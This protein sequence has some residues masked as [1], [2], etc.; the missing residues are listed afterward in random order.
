[1]FEIGKYPPPSGSHAISTAGVSESA[2]RIKSGREPQAASRDAGNGMSFVMDALRRWWK[3]MIPLGLLFAIVS[4]T[5]VFC[6]F[7]PYYEAVYWLRIDSR[8]QHIAFEFKLEDRESNRVYVQ[9][10]IE[11]LRSP[12]ILGP[13]IAKPEI[14]RLPEFAQRTDPLQWL[15]K[16]VAVKQVG[17]SELYRVTY[18]SD[19]PS[20]A[21]AVVNAIVNEYFA[22]YKRQ[23]DTQND[24]VVGKLV[25]EQGRRTQ[26]LRLL[27]E[28]VREL[29]I[30]STGKDPFAGSVEPVAVSNHPLAEIQ[31]HLVTAEV[32]Q[33]VLKARLKALKESRSQSIKVSDSLIDSRLETHPE[34]VRLKHD[35]MTMRADLRGLETISVRKEKDPMRMQLASQIAN[36]EAALARSRK[37]LRE[38]MRVELEASI[39]AKKD[40]QIA[41]LENDLESQKITS[42]MLREKYESRVKDMKQISGDTLQ[43]RLKQGELER[44]EKIDAMISERILKLQTEVNAPKRVASVKE[45]IP[46]TSPVVAFP[47]VNML[48]AALSG[49]GFPFA[50]VLGW[51]KITHRVGD[52]VHLECESRHRVLGEIARLPV[53]PIGSRMRDTQ[54]LGFDL[55]TFEE[56]VDSLRTTLMLEEEL[57]DVRYLAITSAINHEG[58]TSIAAQLALS[59]E[60]ATESP[61]LLIDG[62]MRAPDLHRLFD[63][64]LEPGLTKVLEG[65]C[66]IEEAIIPVG[67]SNL[68]LLPA[69]KLRTNPH[70]LFS[71][72]S[73]ESLRAA[74]PDRYRYVIIDTPPILAASEALMLAAMA[75]ASVVC[76][77][78][79]VSRIDQV[80]KAY[81][82]LQ[83][84]GGNPVGLVLNGVPARTYTH[85]YGSYAYG[86]PIG[87]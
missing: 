47:F 64:P 58:K 1:M 63:V 38:P 82:R 19:S 44:S 46:P 50:L 72:G 67:D 22:Y 15:S 25:Q 36:T 53:R 37:E 55:R 54:R 8:Q 29:A 23:D 80:R 9:T 5:A 13:V 41:G 60:R 39:W 65:V 57:H 7:V 28:N 81:D 78:R 21:S 85:R 66:T 45:A 3:I 4:A 61:I 69:G 32:E 76:A 17:E 59:L 11:L 40:E 77:L 27:R 10:Q 16:R 56:S 31:N 42:E 75:D 84:T 71:N 20:A 34:I 6:F 26:E 24:E 87:A 73:R 68:F 18:S 43:L 49:F 2:L 14:A 70:H 62:D 51:E 83:A 35:L 79:D 48:V 30:Q 33:Q 86:Q 12:M 74:I 52:A